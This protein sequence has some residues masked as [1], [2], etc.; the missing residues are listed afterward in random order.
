VQNSDIDRSWDGVAW[1][2]ISVVVVVGG[3]G[4]EGHRSLLKTP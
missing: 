2:F 3:K 4:T 1:G